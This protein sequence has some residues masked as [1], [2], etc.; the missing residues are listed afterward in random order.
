MLTSLFASSCLLPF[1]LSYC[2]DVFVF[3]SFVT[4]CTCPPFYLPIVR[5]GAHDLKCICYI[6]GTASFRKSEHEEK[7]PVFDTGAEIPCVGQWIIIACVL[8]RWYCRP[9]NLEKRPP[10]LRKRFELEA[11]DA[12]REVH[13]VLRSLRQCVTVAKIRKRFRAWRI[14]TNNEKHGCAAFPDTCSSSCATV[15][16]DFYDSCQESIIASMPTTEQTQFNSFYTTCTEAAQQAAAAL[17]GAS[18]A[19][20]FH[21]VVID[22]EAEQ[23]AAMVNGGSSP[24]TSHFG[25][26]DLPEAPTPTPTSGAVTAQEF[27]VV[28]TLANLTVCTPECNSF[29]YGYLL[30]MEVDGRGTVMT[31]NVMDG[32]YAWQGQ[33]S[34]G[35]FIGSNPQAFLSAVLSGASGTYLLRADGASLG[36]DTDIT[37]QPGQRV[38]IIANGAQWGRGT[39]T[40]QDQ[41]SLELIGVELFVSFTIDSGT[42]A[43]SM[44]DCEVTLPTPLIVPA[45]SNVTMRV[46]RTRIGVVRTVDTFSSFQFGI[47]VEGELSMQASDLFWGSNVYVGMKLW[48]V[49]SGE[50]LRT[51]EGH[52]NAVKSVAFDASGGTLA[53]GSNDHIVK[54]WDVASGEC[55]RTLEGHSNFVTSVAFDAS[56]GTL[57]SVLCCGGAREDSMVPVV[58]SLKGASMVRRADIASDVRGCRW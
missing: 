7:I 54:L 58:Y 10:Y 11:L 5:L 24:G 38:Q 26:V 53:S 37:I 52:S 56:G 25:P 30:S 35:G 45:G 47:A 15:F 57:A 19:M 44:R 31:C 43:L 23:Q 3:V 6:A 22:Q 12:K 40:I 51:L 1:S 50:C 8:L 27:R 32:S 28:C 41:G 29:K 2:F 9:T 14:D 33:A 42:C 4:C 21:V 20:I 34:L 39:I 46:D 18:P 55:L 36:I 17:E 48:D 13:R 49:A 16:T